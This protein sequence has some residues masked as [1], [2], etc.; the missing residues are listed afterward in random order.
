MNDGFSPPSPRAHARAQA[1]HPAPT[2]TLLRG[3]TLALAALLLAGIAPGSRASAQ[4]PAWVDTGGDCLRMRTEP[5]L[6]AAD[7]ICLDHGAAITLLPGSEPRDGFTWQ[8]VSYEGYTGWVADFYV[9]TDQSEVQQIVETVSTSATAG[10]PVPPEGGLTTGVAAVGDPAALAAAQP[11]EVVSIWYFEVATQQQLR[12]IPGAPPQ[13]NTLNSI[14]AEGVVMVR[15]G[16]AL[17]AVEVV[18]EASLT[19]AGTPNVLATPP[20]GGLTQG[21]SGTTDPRF[22]VQ[23]QDFTAE[24]VSYF[25]VPS[26]QWLVYVA[27]APDAANTLKQGHMGT[28]SIVWVRRGPDAPKPPSSEDSDYFETSITYYYCV[29]GSNPASHGDGG[30]YCGAMS[31]GGVVHEGAAAC[32]P[33][34]LGQ[35]FRIEGDPTGRVYTCTDAGGSVLQDH[36]DIWFMNSDDGYAWWITVGERAFIHIIRDGSPDGG[37]LIG[38]TEPTPTPSPT[39]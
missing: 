22:L 10:L 32:A 6:G 38:S 3:L 29:P 19:V 14:P 37:A 34:H 1:A 9:T 16:G 8:Q 2:R 36:R 18:P 33:R 13:V 35:R 24:S 21:V 12:Y 27:G 17:G 15:R 7:V 31:N 4:T 5:G 23:A 11:Y 25:H 28:D 30:G 20:I 26:Q 39:E